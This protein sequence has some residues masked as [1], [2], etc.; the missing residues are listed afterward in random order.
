MRWSEIINEDASCGST[1]A[2]NVA[3]ISQPIGGVVS[4]QGTIGAGFGV[5]PFDPEGQGIYNT[6]KKKKKLKEK[7]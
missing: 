2:G 7:S 5:S 4:R 1:S 3:T 6:K